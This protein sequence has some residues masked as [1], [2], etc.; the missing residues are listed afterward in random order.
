[1][2]YLSRGIS[3]VL[4]SVDDSC[5]VASSRSRL[6]TSLPRSIR[7][8]R[9]EKGCADRFAVICQ[10]PRVNLDAYLSRIGVSGPVEVTLHDLER[11][12]RAHLTAV[13]FENLDVFHRRGVQTG[14]EW[15]MPKIVTRGRGG[16]CFE[17]NGAFAALLEDLGFVVTR[18]AATV[19]LPSTTASP[20][21]MVPTHLTLEVTLDRPYLVDVGFGDSF[22]RPLPLTG[23]GP[24]DGGVG[25]F[26]LEFDGDVT[27][28]FASGPDG[29]EPQYRFGSAPQVS[30]DFDAASE[31]LQTKPGLQWT[32]APFATRLLDGGPDRVTLVHDRIKFRRD[33]EWTEEPVAEADWPATLDEWFDMTP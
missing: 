31:M 13:P 22:I 3:S 18:F 28:L 30:A 23:V 12:Q 26:V 6:G 11:L 9:G 15:S 14:V 20:P 24:H 27:T 7:N 8:L 29:P 10:N 19:L 32:Q 2:R 5:E 25:E 17:L 1:M 21:S 33:G 16:W 4:A